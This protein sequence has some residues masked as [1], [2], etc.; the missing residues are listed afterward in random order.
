MGV[1][2]FVVAGGIVRN[3]DWVLEESILAIRA[4]AIDALYYVTGDNVD[5]TQKILLDNGIQHTV[6]NTGFPGYRRGEYHS[7]NMG[8]LRQLWV[9]NVMA[10]FPQATHLWSVDSD[11]I[12]P[13][14]AL[15][16]LLSHDKDVIAGYVPV[17]NNTIPIHMFGWAEEDG[18]P[19]RTGEERHISSQ[20]RRC[21]LV[22]ACVLMK[23][24]TIEPLMPV[25]GV[26]GQGEDGFFAKRMRE[27]GIEQ[28]VDPVVITEHR[29]QEPEEWKLKWG[30]Q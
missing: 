16:N 17:A 13:S 23:R 12:V 3:R 21:S 27:C 4:N 1:K 25:Y 26:D 8:F 20:I 6:V 10:V 15:E 5:N 2:P 11:V 22:G 24:K 28:W 30:V 9:Q 19:M 18:H 7:S 14:N 29:M